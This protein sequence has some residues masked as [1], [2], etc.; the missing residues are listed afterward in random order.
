MLRSILNW[1]L[2]FSYFLVFCVES[3]DHFI[4]YIALNYPGSA[5]I[6]YFNSDITIQIHLI[7]VL[8]LMLKCVY[9][10]AAFL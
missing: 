5:F 8:F 6:S 4:Y 9:C 7:S 1:V 2:N 10:Q 3:Y